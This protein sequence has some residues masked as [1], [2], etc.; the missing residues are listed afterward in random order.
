MGSKVCC[1]YTHACTHA[2]THT[3]S[4]RKADVGKGCGAASAG[5]GAA[6]TATTANHA[7]PPNIIRFF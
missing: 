2:R 3:L 7:M 6:S 1:C 5:A 4:C